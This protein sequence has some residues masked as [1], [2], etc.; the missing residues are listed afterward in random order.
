MAGITRV[1]VEVRNNWIHPDR[2]RTFK[3][4]MKAFAKSCSDAGI[5]HMI[6]EHEFFESKSRKNRKRRGKLE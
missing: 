5:G 1:K 4:L 3:L 6:K 2:D